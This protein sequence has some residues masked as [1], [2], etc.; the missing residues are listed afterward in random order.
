[1]EK[2]KQ[3]FK[4]VGGPVQALGMSG[5]K[6]VM[7]RFDLKRV[8]LQNQEQ[9]SFPLSPSGARMEYPKWKRRMEQE[10]TNFRTKSTVRNFSPG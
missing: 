7:K 10:C 9:T 6:E 4:S 2:E 5:A 1:M 8:F 3:K